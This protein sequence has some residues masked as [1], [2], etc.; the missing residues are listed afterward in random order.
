MTFLYRVRTRFGGGLVVGGG[1]ND[2]YFLQASGTAAQ[3]VAA[4]A[5]LYNAVAPGI[6]PQVTFVTDPEVLTIDDAT[7]GGVTITT[8]T[9]NNGVGSGTGEP[10][11]PTTQGLIRLR[12]AGFVGG[13]EIRGRI[14]IPGYVEARN[15]SVGT[16]DS[17]AI[18]QMNNGI[19]ALLA[20]A[21]SDLVVYSPTHH[22]SVPVLSAN[23]W[24]QWAVLRSRRD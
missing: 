5:A 19:A 15:S 14:F 10:L 24:G 1:I 17:T 2:L 13:R 12:T 18:N 16:P 6:S 4:V 8:I 20:A 7:G 21:N 23:A 3:A 9:P 22:T 11:P